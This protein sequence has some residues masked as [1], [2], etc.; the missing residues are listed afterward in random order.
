M[1][2]FWLSLLALYF[3]R[4]SS[5]GPTASTLICL[6]MI[7]QIYI[8]GPGTMLKLLTRTSSTC[9]GRNISNSPFSKIKPALPAMFPRSFMALPLR[10]Q[11]HWCLRSLLLFISISNRRYSFYCFY[12][13]S[14]SWTYLLLSI[15]IPPTSV[16]TLII[17]DLD[18]CSCLLPS[19]SF[20][21]KPPIHSTVNVTQITSCCLLAQKHSVAPFCLQNSLALLALSLK[22]P[23]DSAPPNLSNSLLAILASLDYA[24]LMCLSYATYSPC[25]AFSL[26]C[27]IWKR[28]HFQGPVKYYFLFEA[29]TDSHHKI[30]CQWLPPLL[31]PWPSAYTST[32]QL[33]L[34]LMLYL[35]VLCVYTLH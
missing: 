14:V 32:A 6:V 33:Q 31:L 10:H 18:W 17:S 35:V 9:L 5:S 1:C 28:T 7:L 22:G 21:S 27:H 15:S 4:A 25:H 3:L 11:E 30:P 26:P 24:Q 16:H 29:L 8:F 34:C 13:V 19:I 2:W 23:Q 20:P 12:P